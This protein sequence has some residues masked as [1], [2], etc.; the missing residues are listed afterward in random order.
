VDEAIA[1]GLVSHRAAAGE[2]DTKLHEIVGALLAKP[3][4]A[5]RQTQRLLRQGAR[6]EV[7]ERMKLES[8]LFAERLSSAEVKEA[9]SAFFA[10]RKSNSDA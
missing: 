8:G 7:L 5:L 3:P 6:D 4:Q 2:L 1:I 9:I 10:K